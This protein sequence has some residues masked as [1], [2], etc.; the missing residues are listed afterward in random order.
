MFTFVAK[1][2]V[3]KDEFVFLHC[4][5]LENCCRRLSSHNADCEWKVTLC[6]L[7]FIFCLSQQQ[8]NV[9]RVTVLDMSKLVYSV[10]MLLLIF[11][12]SV[13]YSVHVPQIFL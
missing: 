11:V 10:C 13:I 9:K 12:T 7:S 5:I 8:L 2:I 6:F 4:V 3:P 1:D